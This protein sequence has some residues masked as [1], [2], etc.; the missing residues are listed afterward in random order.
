MAT[1]KNL[2]LAGVKSLALYDPNPVELSDLSSQF[3]FTEGDVGKN[4]AEVSAARLRDLNPYVSIEVCTKEL[5]KDCLKEFKVVVLSDCSFERAL[6]V[7]DICHEIGVQFLFAQSKGV[8]GNVFVDFGKDFTVFD[9]NGEEP[10]SAMISAI[11]SENPGVVTTLDEARHGLESGD[12]VTFTEIQGMAE[13]NGCEPIKIEVTG[14]FFL[15]TN[16]DGTKICLSVQG[17][18][19]F[20]IGD[21][22]KFSAYKT[23]GYV[24]QVKMPQ[25]K[26][27]RESLSAPEFIPSDFAKMDKQEQILLGFYAL[28]EFAKQKGE[29]PRPGSLDHAKEVIKIA[30]DLNSKHNN[31]VSEFDEKLLTQMSLNARGDLSPMAAVLGGIVAQEALK[32]CSGK[33][34]PIKQWFVYDVIEALP[35]EYLP[36][37]EV[38]AQGSRYDGQIA[39]FGKTFQDKIMSLNYFLVGAGAIGCEMLKNWAMMGLACA[40]KGC[41]HIT[42]MDTIE[43]SNLNRQ[44]LF[45]S[46]DIQKLKSTTAAEAV[47][48]MN[49][50]LN[51]K[52]YSTRVG[53]DTE[54]LFDDAFFESLDG[55]CNA[56]DNVQA[57]LYVD[58]RCIYY[59]KPLLESGT[60]GTKGNV[61]VVVPN[62]TESYGSSRDPPEK[63]IPICT[64]KNFP[65]AIEHTIQWA[66]DEFEGLF[67]QAAEDAN[68]YLSDTEYVSKLKKQPGT[69]L[70]TLEILRDNLVAKKP[71]SMKDCVVWARLKFEELFVNNIK[72]LLFNFPLD[73]ATAGGT[74]FW[75]GPK[76]APTPLTFDH[77]ANLRAGVFGIEGTRDVAAVKAALSDV[78][79][80]EFTP[81][82]G[83]KIQVNEAEAQQD[84]GAPQDLDEAQLNH[85]ISQLPKPED[86][87][88]EGGAGLKLNPMEFEK[89]DDTNFHI[90]FITACSNLRA[91]NYNVDLITNA[92]KHQTKFIAG[93]IIPAIATTTAMVTGFVCFEL[94]K[95]ARGVKLEQYK[96]AFA[97]LALPL[98]TFSEPIAAPVRKYKDQVTRGNCEEH[99]SRRHLAPRVHRLL[100]SEP[101]APTFPPPALP[102]FLSSLPLPQQ[103]LT[104][105]Q[106]NMDLELLHDHGQEEA[107]ANAD[108]VR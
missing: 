81:Q 53:P 12:Y 86:V 97:N 4:R 76:R 63:S 39:I 42:D 66:R 89:D 103:D 10:T 71:K 64:L 27:M 96:N 72:Q 90:D 48:R 38:K 102:T 61:Q 85:V 68:A 44:F 23:G 62:L 5:D 65:N 100:S 99:R 93:K 104:S 9:T 47:T 56:L 70:S 58:Q 13:L 77:A 30:S 78:M 107:G 15:V 1:G 108:E 82:K 91:T 29:S 33:F 22:S 84:Q 87:K 94:Y 55:V 60:L 88:G 2:A 7:N 80:P 92:D 46:T 11:S 43:K 25:K 54:E 36:E 21:T 45:R 26:S 75:S 74:P 41:I 34:M 52:C 6:Q 83:V 37:E 67:K 18:Y 17:P 32:A 40:P 51:I 57:R 16:F 24:K 79:V 59:Q 20:T 3:Y 73:M 69:G 98:F 28:S 19:T 8:F 49:K 106:K 35:E 95:L 101:S 50:E 14:G 31:L 105:C